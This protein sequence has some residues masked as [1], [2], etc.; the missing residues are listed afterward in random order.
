[1]RP[2]S[3]PLAALL[4]ASAA[5]LVAQQSTIEIRSIPET[6]HE[7]Q[8][9]RLI[10]LSRNAAG[11]LD[12]LR[13][14]EWSTPCGEV[15]AGGRWRVMRRGECVVTAR[16]VVPGFEVKRGSVTFNV[17]GGETAAP[18][19]PP[20]PPPPPPAP[21]PAPPPELP[22]FPWPVP[23]A[24]AWTTVPTRLLGT[25]SADGRMRL[26]EVS[27]S[28]ERAV[29]VAGLPHSVYLL[30]DSG[31]VFVTQAEHIRRS[32]APWPPPDR[33]PSDVR[34]A[35][36][37]DGFLDFIV[38]RFRAR[39]GYFRIIAIV[40]TSRPTGMSTQGIAVDSA[41]TLVHGGLVALPSFIRDRVVRGLACA[42]FV[43]EFQR[44]S[45]TDTLMTL[46]DAPLITAAQH[47]ALA[48]VWRRSV[49]EA[50]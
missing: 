39:P 26:G 11:T 6:L 24:T 47:L 17:L 9:V 29:R 40:V 43:Y 36:A 44:A 5:P 22:Q 10:A 13:G 38:S 27:D 46:R 42:A 31:F 48:G 14:V 20:P 15:R 23:R 30:G 37:T 50:P 35:R 45:V 1:M 4:I 49:L 8:E 16:F 32:G 18:A 33:F 2:R 41:I 21:A 7:G 19:P 28:I 25:Q 3:S 34:G 12:T